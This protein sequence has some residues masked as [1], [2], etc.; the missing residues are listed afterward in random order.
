MAKE[1]IEEI[2]VEN[3]QENG[4]NVPMATVVEEQ[5]G[6]GKKAIKYALAF[7]A[8]V[9]TGIVGFILGKNS[10]KDENEEEP[11]SDENPAE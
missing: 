1:N 2:K 7:V 9:A 10:D 11:A 4:T 6:I 3:N 5:V 8:A